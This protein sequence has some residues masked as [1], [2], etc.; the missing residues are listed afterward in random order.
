MT[1]ST[2]ISRPALR[3][4]QTALGVAIIA[5]L[6]LAP[7]ADARKRKKKRTS[8]DATVAVFP[9]KVLNP[10]QSYAHFG[11]GA[12]DAIVTQ[13]VRA[14]TVKIVEESQLDKAVKTIARNA[15]GLFEEESALEIGRMVDARFIVIGSVDVLAEQIAVS[16]RVLEVET[17]QLIVADRVHGPVANAFNLYEELGGRL[18]TQVE[19]HLSARVATAA[20]DSADAVAVGKLLDDGKKHDPLFGGSDLAAAAGFYEKAVLRS[21]NNHHARF[22]L[23]YALVRKGDYKRG[24]F[25]LE[26]A[27]KIDDE[28]APS[29][30]WL[31]Y[32]EEK[33]GKNDEGRGHYREALDADPSYAPARFFLAA[34]LANQGD[35]EEARKHAEEARR[36]GHDRADSLLTYIDKKQ[37][38][39]AAQSEK[40]AKTR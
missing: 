16:A 31:G 37:E 11:E 32:A 10:E 14:G 4:L 5:T 29:L 24:Q 26:H 33:L 20:G 7:A 9:F 28:H 25:N 27:A 17:R 15:T 38:R 2:L 35:L 6:A 13:V 22:A 40:N 1:N 19:K 3:R 21:P 12:S 30:A 39:L 36:L 34:S 8:R 23:G 18:T